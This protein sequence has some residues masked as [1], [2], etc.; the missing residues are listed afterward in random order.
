MTESI[1]VNVKNFIRAE[2]DLYFGRTVK[3][4]AFGRLRHR[5]AMASIDDHARENEPRHTLL[6][7]GVFD[8]HAAP[9]AVTLP[10]PGTRFMSL[11]VVSQD[12]FAIEVVYPRLVASATPKETVV[13]AM[14]S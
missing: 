12:H 14:C 11:Q 5:R 6:S 1:P 7:S 4:G 2:T 10:D 13:R 9:V 8:L 3:D